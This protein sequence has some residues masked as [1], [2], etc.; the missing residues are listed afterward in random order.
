MTRMGLGSFVA[1]F[2]VFWSVGPAL[3]AQIPDK[4]RNLQVLPA[5]TARP[6]LVEVMRGFAGALGVRCNHCHVGENAAT[7][8]G[9]DFASDAKE[10]KK[11]ARAMM[12]MTREI[13][14][15]LLPATG[16]AKLM[17]VR[18]I[19]CHRGLTRPE[20]LD[21]VVAAVIDEKGV[22]AGLERYRELRRSSFG[23]GGYDFGPRTLS[24]VAERLAR[25]R[26]DPDGALSVVGANLE[27][28]PDDPNL[29]LIQG[30]LLA[31]KG[32]KEAALR[33]YR[34]CL[35]LQPGN[36]RAQ[37]QVEALSAP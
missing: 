34:K 33:S 28:H 35:E 23:Q 21:R 24:I 7:L 8:E 5:E 25:D 37:S 9:F 15:T 27:F 29:H 4:F 20:T 22:A 26:N 32:D 31:K 12:R 30:D 11:I 36:R 16:R 19:T 10:E 14:Q 18:C 6:E 13:N 2:L 17:E 1:V 3:R